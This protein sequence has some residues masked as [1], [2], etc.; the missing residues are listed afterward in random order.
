MLLSLYLQYV[1][2]FDPIVAGLIMIA[3]PVVQAIVSPIS[4]RLSDRIEPRI[5]S[6]VGMAISAV[7]ILMLTV[8]G[9]DTTILYIMASLVILGFGYALFSSP[10]TYA[11]M[12]SVSREFLG[13]ASATLGTARQIGM[14]VSLAISTIVFNIV[15]GQV[16]IT[17]QYY[18]ALI[19]SVRIIFAILAGICFAAVFASLARG[20]VHS[21]GSETV[22]ENGN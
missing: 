13:I 17:P 19:T 20:N 7:G 12:S 16:E 8:I 4:G 9:Q 22:G 15:I 3:S 14:M 18:G 10:N 6:S 21:G 11:V 2:G 5:L 1:K